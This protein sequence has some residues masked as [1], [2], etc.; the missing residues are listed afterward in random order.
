MSTHNIIKL[1]FRREIR[2]ILCGYPLLSVAMILWRYFSAIY[3]ITLSQ[4]SHCIFNPYPAEPGYN[5]PLQTV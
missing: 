1:C 4:G 2:K 5:L 3:D